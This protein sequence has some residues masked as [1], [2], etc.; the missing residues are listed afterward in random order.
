MKRPTTTPVIDGPIHSPYV[1]STYFLTH[2]W[3]HYLFDRSSYALDAL[4]GA[5]VTLDCNCLLDSSSYALDALAGALVTLDCNC[6]FDSSSYALD[7][8]AGAIV[9]LDCNC[10]L[11][12][13]SY[14][15]DALAGALVTVYCNCLL[16]SSSYALDALAGALVTVY[17]N[18]LLDSSS[19]ALDALA[20]A[21]AMLSSIVLCTLFSTRTCSSCFYVRM[22]SNRLLS[23]V[24][25]IYYFWQHA[26]LIELPQFFLHLCC[27]ETII[28][29]CYYNFHSFR[30]P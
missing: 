13:S 29:W 4:A 30:R 19:Y 9:T 23:I 16:D 27:P 14:A 28:S 20:G 10:L 26:V 7:A 22:F 25:A 15:L 2:I 11:D 17:C 3:E 6:L 24:S 12:S 8:L 1:S 21:I 18:C 5:L